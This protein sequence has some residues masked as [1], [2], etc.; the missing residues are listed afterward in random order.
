MKSPK[1]SKA[2]TKKSPNSQKSA[3]TSRQNWLNSLAKG[4]TVWEVSERV[5]IHKVGDVKYNFHKETF[6]GWFSLNGRKSAIIRDNWLGGIEVLT[7]NLFPT[8]KEAKKAIAPKILVAMQKCADSLKKQL[9]E[10]DKEAKKWQIL[11]N[12]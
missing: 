6:D 1:L 2:S 11:A 3:K 10:L 9:K 12:D 5:F 8:E 4:D 7:A